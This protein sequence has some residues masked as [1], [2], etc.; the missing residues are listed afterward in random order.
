MDQDKAASATWLNQAQVSVGGGLN[1]GASTS[2]EAGGQTIGAAERMEV[3]SDSEGEEE[4]DDV[5]SKKKQVLIVDSDC[6]S[7]IKTLRRRVR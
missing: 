7:E 4:E 6:D 3:S 1:E 2:K 5:S